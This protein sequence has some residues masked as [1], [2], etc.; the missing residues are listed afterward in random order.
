MALYAEGKVGWVFATVDARH[1]AQR[2]QE[3]V[4]MP[5]SKF[6]RPAW[7]VG[8]AKYVPGPEDQFFVR[9]MEE[10][11]LRAEEYVVLH[12]VLSLATDVKWV[13]AKLAARRAEGGAADVEADMR[14]LATA[15]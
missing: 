3:W 1:I 6:T 10:Y 5:S 2:K 13:L 11:P 12:N 4:Q 8:A 7:V 14:G 15:I 9:L